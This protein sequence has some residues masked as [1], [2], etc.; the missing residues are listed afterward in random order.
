MIGPVTQAQPGARLAEP[1]AI[2]RGGNRAAPA[3][4]VPAPAQKLIHFFFQHSLQEPLHP[5]T[6]ERLE[7][8]PFGFLTPPPDSVLFFSQAVS[9]SVRALLAPEVLHANRRLHRPL[10]FTHLLTLPLAEN[11]P[12]AI[13]NTPEGDGWRSYRRKLWMSKKGDVPFW[14]S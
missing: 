13:H 1:V 8:R 14:G 5:L 6:C 2:P 7:R 3:A 10:S 9:P 12:N 11:S 4:F